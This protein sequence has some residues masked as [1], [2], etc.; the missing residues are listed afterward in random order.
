MAGAQ[1]KAKDCSKVKKQL[2]EAIDEYY[3]TM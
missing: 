1:I 3:D 2:L